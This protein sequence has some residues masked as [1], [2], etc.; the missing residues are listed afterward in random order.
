MPANTYAPRINIASDMITVVFLPSNSMDGNM[1]RA[2]KN[3]PAESIHI[4]V[5]KLPNQF[6]G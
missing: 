2:P 1:K 3:P 4:H 6:K 5:S